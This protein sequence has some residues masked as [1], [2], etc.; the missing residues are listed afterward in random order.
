[1]RDSRLISVSRATAFLPEDQPLRRLP[2]APNRPRPPQFQA[3]YEDRAL[4]YDCFWHADGRRILL[5]GPP[6]MNLRPHYR[7][8][9]YTAL[10]S[11]TL[12]KA[13]YHASLSTMITELDGVPAGTTA[14]RAELAGTAHEL[15]VGDN[16]AQEFEGRRLL[17]TMSRD[18][19]LAWIAEWA[20]WHATLHGTDAV[21]L[22]DNGSTRYGVDDIKQALLAVPGLKHV[23][24][25]SWPGRFGMTD[26]ALS[27]NPYWSHF[28]Q[29]SAM[30]VAL[31]R[32]GARAAG[33]LNCDIDELAATRSGRPIYDHLA[34]ARHGLVVFRGQWIEA[35]G[36]GPDHSGFTQRL[37]DTAA[38]RSG[39]RKWVLDPAR[40]WVGD[41]RVHPYWHWVRGRPWF[42]KT[43]PPDALY[44]HFK[45][46]NTNWKEAR[47]APPDPAMLEPDSALIADFARLAHG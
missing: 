34:D 8:A 12:L 14:V 25:L 18:N 38:A 19:D 28:L 36:S 10:P 32:F 5:V 7:E 11:G 26:E 13:R 17:F 33:I 45:A 23:A 30:S 9:R 22:F 47:T 6:P 37:R 21:V 4:I 44:R 29:I 41:L 20:R 24:V 2:R 42:G 43:M 15:A 39:P 46:I 3:R 1:V 27:I 16:F 40:D 35:A 31:R